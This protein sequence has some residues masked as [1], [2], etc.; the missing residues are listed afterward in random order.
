MSEEVMKKDVCVVL[1]SLSIVRL[2][3]EVS[4]SFAR[5]LKDTLICTE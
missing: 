2:K 1:I 3:R 4:F 5:H